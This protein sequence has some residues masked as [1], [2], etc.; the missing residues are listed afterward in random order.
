M[1]DRRQIAVQGFRLPRDRLAIAT[2]GFRS[3]S[4]TPTVRYGPPHPKGQVFIVNQPM[5]MVV[6]CRNVV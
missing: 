1:S 2:H 5:G 3:R 6:K 4:V